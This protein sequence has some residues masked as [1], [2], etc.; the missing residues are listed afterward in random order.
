MARKPKTRLRRDF[1]EGGYNSQCSRP[2]FELDLDNKSK[3]I[4]Q[5]PSLRTM[6]SWR[7]HSHPLGLYFIPSSSIVKPLIVKTIN[8]F[9]TSYS[10][11]VLCPRQESNLHFLLRRETLCPLNYEGEVLTLFIS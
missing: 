8:S 2:V 4:L 7:I 1:D 5:P 9:F 6:L 3:H 11:Q 10:Q